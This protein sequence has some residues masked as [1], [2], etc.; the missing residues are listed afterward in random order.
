MNAT[1][2]VPD[3]TPPG[4][5]ARNQFA[6]RPLRARRLVF[7][8]I[9]LSLVFVVGSKSGML[10]PHVSVEFTSSTSAETGTSTLG[11]VTVRLSNRDSTAIT[12]SHLRGANSYAVIKKVSDT[13]GTV[14]NIEVPPSGSIELRAEFEYRG[15]GPNIL[16]LPSIS[17]PFLVAD[18]TT[19]IGITRTVPL[20]TFIP[21]FNPKATCPA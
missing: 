21:T 20:D 3:N 8:G 1:F 17:I 15:C 14:D 13:H 6:P 9:L 4:G 10:T 7:A 2:T 12:I 5:T 16:P 11:Q 19:V 18:V